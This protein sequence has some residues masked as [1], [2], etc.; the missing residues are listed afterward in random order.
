MGVVGDVKYDGVDQPDNPNRA[1]FYTS[2]LQFSFPDTMIIVK[3]RAAAPLVP[4]RQAVASMPRC[5]SA[6][7]LTLDDRL[8][9]SRG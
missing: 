9:R 7:V 4:A 5:R 2:Y 3:A 6:G 8:A 1:D